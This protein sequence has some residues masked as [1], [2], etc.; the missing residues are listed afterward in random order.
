MKGTSA[1]VASNKSPSAADTAVVKLGNIL[2]KKGSSSQAVPSI[3]VDAGFAKAMAA[4]VNSDPKVQMAKAEVLQRQ[5]KLGVTKS[6]LDFQFSGT[7]YGG[8]E[9]ITDNISGVAG[10]LSAS[11]VMYDG[12]QV[13]NAISADRYAVQSALESYRASVDGRALEVGKAWIELERYKAL[14]SLISGRLAVLDPLIMQLERVA[15]AGVGDATQVVAAQRTVAM[16]RVTEMDIQERLAQAE[17]NFTR[18]HG[19]L[20]NKTV[21]DAAAVAKVVPQEVTEEMAM[22]APGILASYA[23]YMSA[24][25]QLEAAKVRESVTVGLEAKVQRP[26]G[27]SEYDSDESVGL[28]LRKIIYNGGKLKSE[29]LAA[30]A[31]VD[32][33]EASLK[34]AYRRGREVIETAMQF[35]SSVDK[36][37]EMAEINAKSLRDEI[38]LLRKQLVIGQSNLE[39]VMSAEARLYEAESKEI[40]FKAD[41]RVSQITVLSAIGRLSSLIGITI[42]NEI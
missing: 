21:F 14:N 1:V 11:K 17:L 7:V 33:Q 19:K 24:S 37:I 16:I 25:S 36:A 34:V 41:K 12:G 39:S 6:Q 42:E 29:I 35:V 26:F 18:I 23:G 2:F 20:P 8:I 10:I 38:V 30:R 4:A 5:A 3:N 22:L 40:N 13:S 28:V 15:E 32:S 27:N 9:D 31:A